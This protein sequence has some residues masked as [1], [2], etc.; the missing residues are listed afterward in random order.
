M[1]SKTAGQTLT[2]EQTNPVNQTTLQQTIHDTIPLSQHM[3][4]TINSLS[5]QHIQVSAP[6]SGNVNIHG[7]AFAGSIY[8]VAT[9]TAWAL[10][11][12]TLRS[13]GSG[14]DL[15]LGEGNIKYKAPIKGDLN[16]RAT[17]TDTERTEFLQRLTEKGRSRL[18]LK[19][20][21]N[22]AAYW[23]GKLSAIQR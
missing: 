10:A 22:N 8:A 23:E 4:F 12:Y 1:P 11:Y 20:D 17:L 2:S 9:L 15:V 16:C 13:V 7:T 19:V 21:I 3:G 14:A 5:D 6:L 18:V